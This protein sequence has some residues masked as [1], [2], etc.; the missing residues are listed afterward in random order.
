MMSREQI[1]QQAL[2]LNAEDRM[3]VADVLEQSLSN[4]GFATPEIAAAWSA[5]IE[6][7]LAEYERG[8][9]K[10]LDADEVLVRLHERLAAFRKQQASS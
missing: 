9:V 3:Y 5:E 8:E 10:G 4:D 1:A 2:A 6:R 7:R